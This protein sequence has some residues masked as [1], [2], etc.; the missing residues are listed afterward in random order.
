VSSYS[1]HGRPGPARRVADAL[2]LRAITR[3]ERVVTVSDG[4]W[5][6]LRLRVRTVHELN[7]ATNA[8]HNEPGTLRWIRSAVRP[9]DVFYDVGANI[10][11]FA[12]LAAHRAGAGGRVAAFEPHA[13]T[14]DA[15]LANVALNDLGDRIDVLSCALHSESGHR[16]FLYRSLAAA[17]GLSQVGATRDPHRHDV[18]P[19]ARELK[20]VAAADDL[21][22]AGTIR[23]ANVVKIDVD[24]NEGAVLAGM[25]GLL[26]GARQPRSVQVEVNPEGS[27]DVLAFMR[28]AGYRET[29]RHLTLGSEQLVRAGTDPATLG[30]NVVFE[31][32]PEA[33]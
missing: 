17:S 3:L 5:P 20:A 6:P 31:P 14:V 18:A 9:G 16:P 22:A 21:I 15:L 25:R 7:R 1:G 24:G 19:V 28:S 33:R 4:S 23:P 10:G 29:G 27:A 26:T 32:V 2:R 11:L 30:A 12:L 8:L 13:A